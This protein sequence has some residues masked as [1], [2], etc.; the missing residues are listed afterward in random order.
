MRYTKLKN[1][2]SSNTAFAC[3][4]DRALVSRS[5]LTSRSCAVFH[6]RSIRPFACGRFARINSICNS[7]KAR[8]NC[9]RT[10]KVCLH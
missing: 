2:L 6:N 3:S 5:S 10:L 4:I 1:A 9:V 7:L 8:E